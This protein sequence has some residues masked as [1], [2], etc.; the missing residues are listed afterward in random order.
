MKVFVSI[1]EPDALK[2]LA[3]LQKALRKERIKDLVSVEFEQTKLEPGAMG[4]GLANS[5]GVVFNSASAPLVELVKTLQKYVDS[6]RTE[7]I[8]KNAEG[9]ELVLTTKKLGKEDIDR[10]VETFVIRTKNLT[11]H[12]PIMQTPVEA[13]KRGRP[14]KNPAEN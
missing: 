13:P 2:K 9:D 5:V 7:I 6:F 14:K 12:A 3:N 8:L 1:N 11:Q 10:L 4:A